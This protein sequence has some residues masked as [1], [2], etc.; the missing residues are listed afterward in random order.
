MIE[1]MTCS[2]CSF[3]DSVEQS[4]SSVSEPEEEAEQPSTLPAC[5]TLYICMYAKFQLVV[6]TCM[7]Y[8]FAW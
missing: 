2:S 5:V 3:S 7:L 4:E 1:G 6:G 8:F